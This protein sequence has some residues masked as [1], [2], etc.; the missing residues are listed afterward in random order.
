MTKSPFRCGDT[1]LVTFEITNIYCSLRRR[2][3][4]IASAEIVVKFRKLKNS[5]PHMTYRCRW[6]C[7]PQGSARASHTIRHNLDGEISVFQS[8]MY[9]AVLPVLLWLVTTASL[10]PGMVERLKNWEYSLRNIWCAIN[11][12]QASICKLL[13]SGPILCSPTHTHAPQRTRTFQT[14]EVRT[15]KW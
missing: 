15:P 1:Q 12:C 9:D 8:P 4:V 14:N 2:V 11:R 5:S 10:L 13:F 3:R 6:V 7:K